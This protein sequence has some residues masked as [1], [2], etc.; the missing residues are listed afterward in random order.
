MINLHIP[1]GSAWRDTRTFF[2]ALC[3]L[4]C[5]ASFSQAQVNLT[6]AGAIYNQNFDEA[7]DFAGIQWTSFDVNA[8]GSACTSGAIGTG[9]FEIL[10]NVS[11][12]VTNAFPAGIGNNG[13]AAVYGY[14]GANGANDWI[15]TTAFTLA[16]NK[17]YKFSYFFR[18]GS[19]PEK[20]RVMLTTDN[21][22][23]SAATGVPT[24]AQLKVYP[25]MTNGNYAKDSISFTPTTAGTY[26][27][28][29]KAES[30]A[31]RFFISIDNFVA[32]NMEVPVNDLSVTNI[33]TTVTSAN[34]AGFTAT[35]GFVITVRNGGTAAQ[36]NIS[37]PWTIKRSATP[38]DITVGSGTQT[39][40]SLAALSQTTFN[41][42]GD[43][44]VGGTYTA[45]ANTE[46]AND[47]I[48][49][50]NTF[51]RTVLNP[52]TD[53]TAQGNSYTNELSLATTLNAGW[54]VNP[55]P[56]TT[57]RGWIILTVGT[58][59]GIFCRRDTTAASNAWMF[60][61]CMNL[62]TGTKYRVTYQRARINNTAIAVTDEKIRLYI[63]NSPTIAAMTTQ[64]GAVGEETVTNTVLQTI[65]FD[66]TAT[67]SGVHHIGFRQTSA[68]LPSG[69][70]AAAF[71]GT[72]IDNL[73]VLAVPFNDMAVTS[74]TTPATVANCS[75]FIAATQFVV[76]VKNTGTNPQTNVNVAW[77]IK[78]A[79]TPE[80]T[81]ASGTEI[82]ASIN[83]DETKTF[84]IVG[85][86]TLPGTYTTSATS[87]LANDA[88]PAN[89]AS[90][91]ARLN[92]L[93]DLKAQGANYNN[94]FS[95]FAALGWVAN[96]IAT[97]TKGWLPLNIGTQAAP[98]VV[99]FCRRSPTVANNDWIFSNCFDLAAGQKYRITYQRVKFNNGGVPSSD[100][101]LKMFASTTGANIAGMTT[102]ILP[103]GAPAG[104]E[105]I[106]NTQFATVVMEFTATT[107]GVYH[108]GWQ[109]TSGTLPIGF[110]TTAF[111][112]V[113]IDNLNIIAMPNIDLGI[114]SVSPL[115]AAIDQCNGFTNNVALTVKVWNAGTQAINTSDFGFKYRVKNSLGVVIQ[116]EAA[117]ASGNLALAPN[118]EGDLVATASINM[119]ANRF[120]RVEIYTNNTDGNRLN[121]TIAI[122][123][124]NGSRDLTSL[125]SSYNENFD[126]P[127][128][129]DIDWAFLDAS[130]TANT[131]PFS[132]LTSTTGFAASGTR[133]LGSFSTVD[134]TNAWASTGCLKLKAGL[135][136]AVDFK[137]RTAAFVNATLREKLRVV[138]LN[139]ALPTT[140]GTQVPPASITNIKDFPSLPQSTAAYV[141]GGAT[142]FT[143]P[144]DGNYFIGFNH[145]TPALPATEINQT[146]VLI[147]DV[148]LSVIQPPAAPAA[149]TATPSTT[150][151]QIVLNWTAPATG[152]VTG[153][154]VQR[155]FG[156]GA[157]TTLNTVT[158]LTYTDTTPLANTDYTYQ[159]IAL[160]VT[161]AS[162]P[163]NNVIAKVSSANPN[164][165]VIVSVINQTTGL[166]NV[167]T[168]TAPSPIG[169]NA[170]IVASYRVERRRINVVPAEAF[171]QIGTSTTLTYTDNTGLVERASYEYQVKTV[172]SFGLVSVASNIFSR[173]VTAI[174]ESSLS[175]QISVYPNPSEGKFRVDMQN[176]RTA[177]QVTFTLV[178][179]MGK[180]IYTTTKGNEGLYDLKIPRISEGVYMLRIESSRGQA[181]KRVVIK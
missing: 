95:N 138:L 31:D 14:K 105:T 169:V 160:N 7:N 84:N 168:W 85:D 157:F 177:N 120:Y 115:N 106:T 17:P 43:L 100:D 9:K 46:L 123:Y 64:I 110:P 96:P 178:D 5:F 66:F 26:Y 76:S 151:Y 29:F 2:G 176:V 175:K 94:D 49:S 128:T 52:V 155:K 51:G 25:N 30:D 19:L 179:A 97:A 137:Y 48:P 59:P 91:L 67:A 129:L 1:L 114:R 167:L 56:S 71:A 44:T 102:Q 65:T 16:A 104:D 61:N 166:S 124:R 109:Q 122:G 77:S 103:T 171:A 154:N 147:D 164:A 36:T 142:T 78:R 149:L 50:N 145:Y 41:I 170:G 8:D 93:I 162:T 125:A 6:A 82:V 141:L 88:L 42:V 173:Q 72:L 101:K 133:F 121:D 116:P 87:Q 143:V 165:P 23:T 11:C 158:G 62:T 159:V 90:S 45:A 152:T 21:T 39:I 140:A 161:V 47:A 163:S 70:P 156:A 146:F 134:A 54:S 35:T 126:A 180:E 58:N 135:T 131:D 27:I 60:S 118:A 18:V 20:M 68:Q 24:P 83:G 174:E 136:Y 112:G 4:V 34:C 74:I 153:Y 15:F 55:I 32:Q 92:P 144:A 28:A 113:A 127:S 80:V 13:K 107:A 12:G 63:G 181:M 53:L 3:L 132:V 98:A 57:V 86:L 10:E 40:A 150:V 22:P 37:I 148:V 130:N 172:S 119:S 38:A 111:A 89:D 99:L 139:T 108:F 79:G 75:S 117:L 33:T 69:Y 73:E 81:V